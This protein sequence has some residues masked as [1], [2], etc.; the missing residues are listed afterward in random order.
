MLSQAGVSYRR[1]GKAGAT[2]GVGGCIS[3]FGDVFS[4]R[5]SVGVQRASRVYRLASPGSLAAAV[6][7]NLEVAE[8]VHTV[9]R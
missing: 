3:L 8:T 6:V 5:V 4:Q 7:M 9:S 2:V 1:V